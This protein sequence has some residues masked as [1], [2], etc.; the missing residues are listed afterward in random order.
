MGFHSFISRVMSDTYVRGG[1]KLEMPRGNPTSRM[2]VPGH[3]NVVANWESPITRDM[4]ITRPG[5]KPGPRIWGCHEYKGIS[6]VDNKV[7]LKQE[8]SK[9]SPR[10]MCEYTK[11]LGSN[12]GQGA[13]GEGPK[14]P[15]C[16]SA[17]LQQRADF[18]QSV[19]TTK[20]A[21]QI[22]STHI[23]FRPR[24][25]MAWIKGISRRGII[26]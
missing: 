20:R 22:V 14:D 18:A 1:T 9:G 26:H 5:G 21:Q 8:M 6:E 12:H 15:T 16:T 19:C 7:M 24:G 4:G 10:E 11:G 3:D 17:V 23:R 2:N 25:Y 13:P